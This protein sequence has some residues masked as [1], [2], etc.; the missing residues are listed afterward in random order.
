MEEVRFQHNI[1]SRAKGFGYFIRNSSS[2][3]S[4]VRNLQALKYCTICATNVGL[5]VSEDFIDLVGEDIDEDNQSIDGGDNVDEEE[6]L[7]LPERAI[8]FW[9]STIDWANVDLNFQ[10]EGESR[11][12]LLRKRQAEK[13][14]EGSMKKRSLIQYLVP[15]QRD[16]DIEDFISRPTHNEIEDRYESEGNMRAAIEQLESS[17]AKIHKNVDLEAKQAKETSRFEY[18]QAICIV[19]YL[20]RRLQG[21]MSLRSA[22]AVADVKKV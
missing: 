18:L 2:S 20:Q 14:R 16:Q 8:N 12:T 7:L 5:N 19:R 1:N 11:R 17:I 22:A 4:S 15:L 9:N 21:E 13:K 3:V 10:R 6:D